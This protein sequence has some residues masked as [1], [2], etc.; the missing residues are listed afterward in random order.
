MNKA[1]LPLPAE[2]IP[3]GAAD[4]RTPDAQRWLAAV[5]ARWAHPL[6][7]VLALVAAGVWYMEGSPAAACTSAAPCGT[8]WPGLLMAVVLVLTLYWVWRQPRL[9]LAGLAAGLVGFAEDG[10]FTESFGEP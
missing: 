1:P 2:H 4:W 3:P 7:A 5:P 10:G 6:W 9:A 8:D